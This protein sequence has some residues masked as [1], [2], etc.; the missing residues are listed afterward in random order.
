LLSLLEGNFQ[1]FGFPVFLDSVFELDQGGLLYGL[2]NVEV[3]DDFHQCHAVALI[4][5]GVPGFC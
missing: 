2:I 3:I 1:L 5:E 4:N